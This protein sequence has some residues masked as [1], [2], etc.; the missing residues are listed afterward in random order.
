MRNVNSKIT[1]NGI[2]KTATE[3]AV[4]ILFTNFKR[5]KPALN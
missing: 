2:K 5:V 1:N 3:V 4:L